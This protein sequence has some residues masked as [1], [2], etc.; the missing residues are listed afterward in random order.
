MKR[1]L[2]LLL[3][4][5]FLAMAQ[6]KGV[7]FEHGL[8]WAEVKAKAKAENKYIFMDCFTTWCGPCKFMSNTIFP[9]EQAGAFF[10]DKFVSVKVQLDSTNK[11]NEEV[12]KWR[13]DANKI[14]KDYNVVAYPTFLVF[15]PDGHIV[16][17][18][19]GG[20]QTAEAFITRVKPAL[21][22]EEQYYTQLDAFNKGRR[23]TAFLRK[24][25]TTST[26]LYDKANS[27]KVTAAYLH[28]QKDLL[29]P[30][31]IR[32]LNSAVTSTKSKWF[33]LFLNENEKID[34][35]LGEGEADRKVTTILAN[36]YVKP[37]LATDNVTPA[38]WTKIES[39]LTR[40]YPKYAKKIV[41]FN[42]IHYYLRK[43]D[44]V[45]FRPAVNSYIQ[46]YGK[47]V[48]PSD[49]NTYAW[50]VF[51]KCDDKACLE[52]ALDWS[53]R[54]FEGNNSPALIDTYANLLYKLGRKD[55]AISWEEKAMN[56]L[57]ESDRADF[58]ATINKMKNGQPTW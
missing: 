1:I 41:A 8:S 55:E 43:G 2:S 44:W 16:H 56:A 3:F 54:S 10:N 46:Q 15:A 38:T 17:R 9:Q 11:D 25:A 6:D 28:S 26:Q 19:V 49:L 18:I 22:P 27:E 33:P 53:K 23:D 40:Q 48:A 32:L 42:K 39:K 57:P 7:H 47:D 30:A 34:K 36:E 51:E 5:P 52:A 24:L 37:A 29:T 50:T 14:A 12:N 58:N 45:N 35:V 21:N 4:L 31:N 20:A 13:A